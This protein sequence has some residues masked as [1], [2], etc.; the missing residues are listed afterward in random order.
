[1]LVLCLSLTIACCTSISLIIVHG[2]MKKRVERDA[3]E[4]L[5]R[6]LE[7]WRNVEAQ[8]LRTLQQENALLADLPSLKALMTT[9]DDRTIADSGLDFWKVSGNDLFGLLRRDGHVSALY[10]RG[11]PPSADLRV[12]V[13]QTPQAIQRHYLV[14]EHRLFGYALRPLY[15]GDEASGTLLGYVISGYA[16][17]PQ[18][19]QQISRPAGTDAMFLSGEASLADTLHRERNPALPHFAGNPLQVQLDG[20]HYLAVAQD[21][22]GVSTR[23]LRLILLKAMRAQEA[24]IATMRHL[25]AGLGLASVCFGSLVML[26][27][28]GWITEPLQLLASSVR[29][30]GQGE[31]V[32]KVPNGGTREIRQLAIDFT[33]MRHK[34]EEA[35]KALIERERLAAVGSMASSFSHDLRHYL[36]A[37]YANAEFLASS[38]LSPEERLE[39]LND[40]RGAVTGTTDLI[41]S[42]LVFSR[43]GQPQTCAAERMSLI[44]QRALDVLK[45]HPEA[46]GVSSRTHIVDPEQTLVSVDVKQVERALFNLLLNAFQSARRFSEHP[47]V[48]ATITCDV[49]MVY[50]AISDNGAG[51]PESIRDRLFEPF[52]SAGKQNGTGL[53]LT[54]AHRVAQDHGGAATVLQSAAG[55]TIFQFSVRRDLPE[56]SVHA[57][58]EA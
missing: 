35:S 34:I 58:H 21:L 55:R 45:N 4:Q 24:E 6:S 3:S 27:V 14:S 26:L 52:V 33:T 37:V 19:L 40:I 41:D 28:A 29:A 8:Q 48:E 54:L 17:S 42:L 49:Q 56:M 1:M 11:D 15:F 20:E 5:Q 10:T 36:T 44:L 23:P 31:G 43:T 22:S 53:G 2:R 9:D 7:T 50:V 38:N 30:F 25:L 16:V 39:L 57:P 32:Q 12:M 51:V 18:M 13:A 46:E 47:E